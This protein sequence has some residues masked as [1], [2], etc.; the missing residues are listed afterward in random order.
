MGGDPPSQRA[1]RATAV[2]A[3]AADLHPLAKGTQVEPILRA[4]AGAAYAAELRADGN[5][6]VGDAVI[7]QAHQ[8]ATL[9]LVDVGHRYSP[10]LLG[11]GRAANLMNTLDTSLRT[12]R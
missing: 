3:A 8:R 6:A 10:A 12:L 7:E 11:K 9:V 1:A 5:P 2:A 4:A